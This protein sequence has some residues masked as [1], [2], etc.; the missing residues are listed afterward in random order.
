ML[1]WYLNSWINIEKSLNHSFL[2]EGN[3]SR[4]A[5]SFLIN[6][7]KHALHIRIKNVMQFNPLN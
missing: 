1:S 2:L 6:W 3:N 7:D 4:I 5:Y